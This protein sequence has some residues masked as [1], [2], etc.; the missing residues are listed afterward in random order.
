MTQSIH[1][2]LRNSEIG[3][4]CNNNKLFKTASLQGCHDIT[5]T[6]IESGFNIPATTS[7]IIK[8]YDDINNLHTDYRIFP[9]IVWTWKLQMTIYLEELAK[10]INLEDDEIVSVGTT[11]VNRTSPLY[12]NKYSL[13][14]TNRKTFHNCATILIKSITNN[15]KYII[16][17]IFGNGSIQMH[18]C[19]NLIDFNYATSILIRILNNFAEDPKKIILNDPKPSIIN[20]YFRGLCHE[21][22]LYKLS[23]IFSE[24]HNVETEDKDIGYIEFICD[25]PSDI[26]I[27]CPNNS[28]GTIFG[29]GGVYIFNIA[30]IDQIMDIYH[31]VMKILNKYADEIKYE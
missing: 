18:H 8:F 12:E 2:L 25:A 28:S 30:N 1:T 14:G 3:I 29:S 22:N 13:R 9:Q 10:N 19:K 23:Q 20:C 31:Y 27:K 7:T 17:K 24:K 16:V 15:K 6:L 4:H 5:K 21:I 11:S 26:E